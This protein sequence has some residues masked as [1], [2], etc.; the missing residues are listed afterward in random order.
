[1]TMELEITSLRVYVVE[2][3]WN[4]QSYDFNVFNTWAS[5]Y[6]YVYRQM[7]MD[8]TEPAPTEGCRPEADL[9][10]KVDDLSVRDAKRLRRILEQ[11]ILELEL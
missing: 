11:V 8:G 1:M 10:A 2:R 4:G 3:V 7:W 6:A 9:S 5:A